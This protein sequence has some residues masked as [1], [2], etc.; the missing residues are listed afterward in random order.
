LL[1]YKVMGPFDE[2]NTNI[3]NNKKKDFISRGHSFDNTSIFHEGL[4]Q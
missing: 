1:N 3:N 4:N 2:Y